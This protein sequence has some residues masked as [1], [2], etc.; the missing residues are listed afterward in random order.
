MFFKAGI[1]EKRARLEEVAKKCAELG[2]M[3][4][5][6]ENLLSTNLLRKRDSLQAV[7]LFVF[8][9]SYLLALYVICD[10]TP[11]DV[12]SIGV[13]TH[14]ETLGRSVAVVFYFSAIGLFTFAPIR[15]RSVLLD[16]T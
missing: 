1:K 6:M 3:K 8:S 9:F 5:Q 12:L 13:L 7:C 2:L 10:F 15:D 4:L 11:S 14:L 16:L